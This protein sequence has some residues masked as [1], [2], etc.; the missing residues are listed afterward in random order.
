[1]P[2]QTQFQPFLFPQSI[3]GDHHHYPFLHLRHVN[4]MNCFKISKNLSLQKGYQNTSFSYIMESTSGTLIFNIISACLPCVDLNNN[5]VYD[6]VS[7]AQ[8]VLFLG[9]GFLP[10]EQVCMLRENSGHTGPL[11]RILL[12]GTEVIIKGDIYY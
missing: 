3:I 10:S 8:H 5:L 12:M 1:M 6:W 11:A 7:L 2:C 9:R 4:L